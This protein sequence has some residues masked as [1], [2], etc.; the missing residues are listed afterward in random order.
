MKTK[1]LSVVV[2]FVALSIA[3]TV[4]GGPAQYEYDNL[5]RLISVT[6]DDG[7][8]ISYTYDALGNR[9]TKEVSAAAVTPTINFT[10]INKVKAYNTD[11]SPAQ[12][13]T[14]FSPGTNLKFKVKFT[15]DGNPA[16][17]YK[18]KLS[19]GE[20]ILLYL[21][22]SDPNRVTKLKNP[23]GNDL[24]V[25]KDIAPGETRIVKLVGYLPSDAQVGEK[26]KFKGKV[27][28]F[29]MGD[30]T[31]IESHLVSRKFDIV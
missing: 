10:W 9:L 23:D 18:V 17:L 13:G 25:Q 7:T 28:L 22:I 30:P 15:V 3:V 5:H 6:Y 20:L 2:L 16:K 21:P 26:F 31:L 27:K 24:D 4:I 14:S 8:T 11:V 29:E 12:A 1:M 19:A